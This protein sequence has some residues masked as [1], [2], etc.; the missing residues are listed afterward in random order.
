[1][2]IILLLGLLLTHYTSIHCI[3]N[4]NNGEMINF[5]CVVQKIDGN[6]KHCIKQFIPF[7]YIKYKS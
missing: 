1:M 2:A 5:I 4:T 6:P 7:T 3:T